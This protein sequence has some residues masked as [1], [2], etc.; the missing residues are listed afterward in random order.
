MSRPDRALQGLYPY[1]DQTY[2]ARPVVRSLVPCRPSYLA[3]DSNTELEYISDDIICM[4]RPLKRRKAKR[5]CAFL[6]D[7]ESMHYPSVYQ[8]FMYISKSICSKSLNA[9]ERKKVTAKSK[10]VA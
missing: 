7:V 8:V 4:R 5:R 6:S 3:I 9:R 2:S 1:L 10:T